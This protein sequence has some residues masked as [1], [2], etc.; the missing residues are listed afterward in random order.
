MVSNLL[1]LLAG[2]HGLVSPGVFYIC[3]SQCHHLVLLLVVLRCP[4]RQS[5]GTEHGVTPDNQVLIAL[6][7]TG[8][9]DEITYII[10][11]PLSL[12]QKF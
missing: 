4:E 2:M 6:T 12:S 11:L 9:K 5:G 3:K 8:Q 7:S 10:Y 1:I